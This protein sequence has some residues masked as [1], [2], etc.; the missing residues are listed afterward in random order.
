MLRIYD[1]P[2][3]TFESDEDDDDD[4]LDEEDEDS[5]D[6]EGETVAK[7]PGEISFES[8]FLYKLN[9][10]LAM[11]EYLQGKADLCHNTG[12][13]FVMPL[14]TNRIKFLPSGL[15]CIYWN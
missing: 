2:N 11:C 4:G 14:K 8:C 9:E 5:E 1:I 15:L 10:Y 13:H 6:S 7:E 12:C 3:N